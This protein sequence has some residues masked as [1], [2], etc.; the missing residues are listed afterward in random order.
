[1]KR[2][3]FNFYLIIRNINNYGLFTIFK[4]FII[5]VFYLLKIRDFKSYIHDDEI[6]SSYDDTKSNK[7]YNMQS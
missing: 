1:M 2:Y 5:E 7:E 4:A 6:T 3:F